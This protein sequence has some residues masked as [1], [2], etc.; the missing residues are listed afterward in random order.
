MS[1][2]ISSKVLFLHINHEFGAFSYISELSVHLTWDK[3]K[4]QRIP[5][6]EVDKI[7]GIWVQYKIKFEFKNT[8]LNSCKLNDEMSTLELK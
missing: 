6:Q 2:S 5:L 3:S 4:Y 7:Y 8:F 1:S